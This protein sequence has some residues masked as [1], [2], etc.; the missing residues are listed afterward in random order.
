MPSVR[1]SRN[2]V[3][4]LP[5]L[6]C[7]AIANYFQ[8]YLWNVANVFCHCWCTAGASALHAFQQLVHATTGSD[9]YCAHVSCPHILH[10][11]WT[12]PP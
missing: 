5:T 6:K 12:L 4:A 7:N 3:V 8:L 11:C 1:R 10:F 2:T 9:S